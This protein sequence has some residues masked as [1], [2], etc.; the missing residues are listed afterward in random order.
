MARFDQS[1]KIYDHP[2]FPWQLR[3]KP[4]GKVSFPKTYVEDYTTQLSTIKRGT[5]LFQ[6]F[7]MDNP[8]ELGGRE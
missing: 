6:V 2:K 1:G 8:E 4:T 3:F 7:A 5:A